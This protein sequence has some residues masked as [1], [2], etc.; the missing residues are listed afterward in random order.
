MQSDLIQSDAIRS[1][2]IRSDAIRSDAIQ[3]L[4]RIPLVPTV[5][6]DG[7]L[8]N[9]VLGKGHTQQRSFCL[10]DGSQ[11]KHSSRM[12]MLKLL[13]MLIHRWVREEFER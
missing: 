8:E 10:H 11:S 4:G 7:L 2:A 9:P 12:L 3:P 6:V 1:D 5:L 13:L